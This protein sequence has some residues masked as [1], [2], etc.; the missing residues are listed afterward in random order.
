MDSYPLSWVV[1]GAVWRSNT[2]PF[3]PGSCERGLSADHA[4][5]R[6]ARWWW[7][8]AGC[9]NSRNAMHRALAGG[10]GHVR[11]THPSG[12]VVK[13]CGNHLR[14][15]ISTGACITQRLAACV[16]FDPHN[17][18]ERHATRP[19]AAS[20]RAARAVGTRVASVG[21]EAGIY[22]FRFRINPSEKLCG[23]VGDPR[24]SRHPSPPLPPQ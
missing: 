1:P 12:V 11:L 20:W 17:R 15:G 13:A 7:A 14:V 5:S 23:H 8:G 4:R 2:S 10:A 24:P 22:G 6:G 19:V 18:C 9:G 3:P 16:W 21:R